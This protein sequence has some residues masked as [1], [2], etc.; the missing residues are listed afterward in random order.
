MKKIFLILAVIPAYM[1]ARAQY[2]ADYLKAA[3]NYY[4]KGDYYSAAQYYEKWLNANKPKGTQASY[5]PYEVKSALGVSAAVAGSQQV[6]YN[7]AESYRKLNYPVKAVAYYEKALSYNNEHHPLAAY[8]YAVT[9]RALGKDEEA[10]KAFQLF[11]DKYKIDDVYSQSARSEVLNLHFIR[12][13]L[14]RK[15]LQ[16]FTVQKQN[17]AINPSGANYSPVWLNNTT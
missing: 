1:M 9:L 16:L 6:V 5:S 17:A 15:D 4:K 11:L 10:E 14:R 8:Y 7:L 12:E 3:D 13:Q 2:V